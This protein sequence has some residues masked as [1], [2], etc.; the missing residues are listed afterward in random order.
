MKL[1]FNFG[2]SNVSHERIYCA[3]IILWVQVGLKVA[4]CMDMVVVGQ[5]RC[6]PTHPNTHGN[7]H[8]Y[9]YISPPGN[10]HKQLIFC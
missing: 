7:W 1:R 8:I 9:I 5:R 2:R 6:L 4:P 10:H 3:I